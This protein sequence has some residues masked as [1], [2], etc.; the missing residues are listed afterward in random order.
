MPRMASRSACVAS[1]G[2]MSDTGSPTKL[3]SENAMKPTTSMTTTP[4]N[5]RRRMKAIT[6]LDLDPLRRELVVGPVDDANVGPHRPR[7]HL[8]VQRDVPH[9]LLVDAAR[10]QRE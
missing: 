7:D 5:S 8:E 10:V 1:G 9:F 2:S 3:K 6:L 4:C